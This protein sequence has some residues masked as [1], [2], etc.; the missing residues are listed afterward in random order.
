MDKWNIIEEI[1]RGK[2][3]EAMVRNI[4][5]KELDADLS[6]LC[7]MIYLILLEYDDEKIIDLWVNNQIQFFIARVIINQYKSYKSPFHTTFRKF[8]HLVN[9]SISTDCRTEDVDEYLTRMLINNE[10]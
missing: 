5:H 6:D 4:A 10:D 1:A 2:M 9:E 8:R 7:Q 3:V